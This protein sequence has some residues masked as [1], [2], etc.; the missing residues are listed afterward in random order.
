MQI[1]AE[2]T[3]RT[4]AVLAVVLRASET[5]LPVRAAAQANLRRSVTDVD[6]LVAAGI[7]IRLVKGAFAGP[8]SIAWPFGEATSLALLKLAGVIQQAGTDLTVG[9]HD[10]VIQHAVAGV[11]V[12]MLLGSRPGLARSLAERGRPVR[13]YVPYGTDWQD[14]AA[15]RVAETRRHAAADPA[16]APSYLSRSTCPEDT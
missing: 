2:E 8:P 11:E 12:E 10:Q 5:G 1:G 15:R 13:V 16:P 9:T 7:P 3:R 4:D 6:R 14:Y